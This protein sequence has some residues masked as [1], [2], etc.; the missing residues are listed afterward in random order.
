MSRV[1][2]FLCF[3][4]VPPR[5]GLLC[6]L[7]GFDRIRFIF[8][9]QHAA[10]NRCLLLLTV[11]DLIKALRGS[12]VDRHTSRRGSDHHDVWNLAS[13]VRLYARGNNSRDIRTQIHHFLF[14]ARF[15][16]ERKSAGW[17]TAA[18]RASPPFPAF[19]GGTSNS[20]NPEFGR[21][22]EPQACNPGVRRE[23]F[24]ILP[25]REASRASIFPIKRG[26]SNGLGS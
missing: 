17:T 19:P 7:S 2:A 22:P 26:K 21:A 9:E 1:D 13:S 25:G 20:N 14:L 12:V 8:G 23:P 11:R 10:D 3:A 5:R 18:L 4:W 6:S 24:D 16:G 15:W